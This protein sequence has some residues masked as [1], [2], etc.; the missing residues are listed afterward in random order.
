[1]PRLGHA[2]ASRR[3]G[4]NASMQIPDAR[5]LMQTAIAH[6]QSGRLQEAE[7]LYRRVLASHPHH[8]DALH[9]LGLL[10]HHMGQHET[11]A[12]LIRKA[13]RLTPKI[14]ACHSN[15]GNVLAAQGQPDEAIRSYRRALEINP[16]FADAHQNLGNALHAK[17]RFEE[18]IRSH[19]RATAL[20]PGR[21]DAHYN[22]G[23]ALLANGEPGEALASYR[24]ALALHPGFADAHLGVG[25][26]LQ[27]QRLHQEALASYRSVVG[28]RPDH[29]VAWNNIGLVLAALGE[30]AQ[31]M[32]AIR[33]SLDLSPGY[34]EAWQN[35]GARHEAQDEPEQALACYRKAVELKPGF[36]VAWNN[37]G[38]ALSRLADLDGALAAYRRALELQPQYADAHNNLGSLYQSLGRLDEAIASTDRA[39]ALQ[40]DS[41]SAHWNKAFALLLRGDYAQ[42]WRLAEWR[43]KLD[44]APRVRQEFAQPA[45]L[46][47]ESI[48]DRTVLL[49]HEQGLGDTLQ[50]LRYA[51]LLAGRGAR[52]VAV[53]PAALAGVAA[54]VR[55]VAAVVTDDEALPAFDLH[56]PFMSLPLACATTL[57]NV[58]APIP[59]VSAPTA[60]R[61]A[62]RARLGER[63]ARR[64]GL[65]WSGAAAHRNDRQRSIALRAL[66][67]WLG[68][69][70]EFISLQK[71]YRPEDKSMLEDAGARIRDVS[72]NLG[73]F[74]DTAGLIANLDL[75]ITVDTSVAHLA[76]AMGAP[77]WLLLPFAPDYRWLLGREDSPW[78]PTMRLWRQPAPGDWETPLRAIGAA[79]A[80]G[81]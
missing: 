52:V 56:C 39:L 27:A 80:A 63:T 7:V 5:Q 22:L 50:M 51:P 14:A 54:T 26:A 32:A 73:D 20:Q 6:H 49:H 67:P 40:P 48:E 29:A 19:R 13:I 47:G 72:A 65:T 57:A 76:G 71:E 12:E 31:A 23:N 66:L 21:A 64:I 30:P 78:Y 25:N 18:A 41:A 59:Y 15:L 70:A 53:V 42:G 60:Q 3:A 17:G 1:M 43:W 58:P 8:P 74:A 75:V 38:N 62:W 44:G 45:W 36:A 16:A 77:T 11:A 81:S 9:M 35:L 24:S 69:G 4:Y 33:R 55:G 2:G 34:A 28:L 46:G 61:E 68:T 10:A 79:L 37:I